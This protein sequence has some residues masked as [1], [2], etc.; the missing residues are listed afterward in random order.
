MNHHIVAD[1]DTDV[2]CPRGIV[3]ALKEYEVAG[4]HIG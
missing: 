2:G 4:A 3:G 1:V